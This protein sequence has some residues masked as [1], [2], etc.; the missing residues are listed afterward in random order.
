[1]V[2]SSETITFLVKG[3]ASEPYTVTFTK[4]EK[5]L[6]TFCTCPAGDKGQYCKHRVRI[7]AGES[8]GIVSDN[9]NDLPTIKA[10]MNGSPLESAI[11]KLR[12]AEDQ[13]QRA[14][15]ELTRT[16]KVLSKVMH[17]HI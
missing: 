17:G 4:I 15:L 1:M 8:T 12:D 10:W 2:G 11:Q 13:V 7:L 6:T 16:K 9:L 14:E 3:S 5:R